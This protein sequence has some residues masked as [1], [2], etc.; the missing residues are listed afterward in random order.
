M[1]YGFSESGSP[2]YF[3]W[4]EACL[5][6]GRDAVNGRIVTVFR[7]PAAELIEES[8]SQRV[9]RSF[10]FFGIDTESTDSRC[11]RISE[12]CARPQNIWLVSKPLWKQSLSRRLPNPKLPNSKFQ[13][14]E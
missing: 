12:R 5:A 9:C 6:S 4:D 1:V 8:G 10:C 14:H 2:D 13:K 11:Q 7:A 3:F